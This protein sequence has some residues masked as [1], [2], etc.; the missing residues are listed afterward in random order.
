M[1]QIS[2][3]KMGADFKIRKWMDFMPPNSTDFIQQISADFGIRKM[4]S[5]KSI[6]WILK[7]DPYGFEP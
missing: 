1:V 5:M 3:S 4:I 6:S 2:T 7:S